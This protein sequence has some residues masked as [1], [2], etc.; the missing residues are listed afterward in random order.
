MIATFEKQNKINFA[1]EPPPKKTNK[2]E[3]VL[4]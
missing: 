4:V 3:T 2:H 1:L